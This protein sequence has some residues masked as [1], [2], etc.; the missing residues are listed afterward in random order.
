ML[1]LDDADD[2]E[3]VA[4]WVE[5]E[6]SLGEPS[7]SKSKV[8]S[9]V[10][11]ASGIEPSESFA[12]DVWRHLRGRIAF[13]STPYFEVRGDM[14]LRSEDIDE[15]RLEY[16][17]CLFF[18]LY[19]A[20]YLT[21]SNPKLFERMSAEAIGRHFG[22]PVFVFGWPVLPDVETAIAER[23]KQVS[24]LLHERFIEAPGSSL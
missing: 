24:E 2:S 1:T 15:G 18:S 7:F 23:V 17:V 12:S 20:S 13:Y 8:S 16:Q 14:V 19:G 3:R 5:L 22:G 21:G 6:L 9:I 4:D 11:D 10:R